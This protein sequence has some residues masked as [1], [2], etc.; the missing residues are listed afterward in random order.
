MEHRNIL[1]AWFTIGWLAVSVAACAPG[2]LTP[3]ALPEEGDPGG[4]GGAPPGDGA[5]GH[6]V[7][8]EASIPVDP[9]S[10]SSGDLAQFEQEL[11][12]RWNAAADGIPSSFHFH[13]SS[14]NQFPHP[15]YQ[16][17]SFAAY[18]SFAE[19][20][21]AF[22]ERGDDFDFLASHDGFAMPLVYIFE[23]G[24]NGLNTSFDKLA[25]DFSSDEGV[26]GGIAASTRDAIRG[27]AALIDQSK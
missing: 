26:Y 4:D 1:C 27:F 17:G 23:S 19:V 24:Q 15:T 12:A 21:R 14:F 22:F 16:G 6:V 7:S 18:A 2:K 9:R 11:M 3:S 13:W 5:K 25:H 20:L 8:D 10:A